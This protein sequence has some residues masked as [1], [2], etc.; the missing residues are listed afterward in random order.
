M[1]SL[2]YSFFIFLFI[3]PKLS[4]VIAVEK[5]FV[6]VVLPVRSRDFWTD[7]T[8]KT[9]DQNLILAKN[10][11]IPFTFLLQYD[12]LKDQEIVDL[13]KAITVPHEIGLFL[14]VGELLAT[15]TKVPYL[16]GSGDWA[17]PDKVFLSG[18]SVTN[19]I[20]MIDVLMKKFKQIF[21]Y[22]PVSVGA[23]YI[24]AASMNYLKEKYNIQIALTA[25]DQYSTDK[26]HLWGKYF[27]FPFYSSKYNTLTPTQT[28]KNKLDVVQIQWAFRD[29]V[30]SYGHSAF[31]S[32]YSLQAN[33]YIGHKLKTSYF[34]YIFNIY[35]DTTFNKFAQITVGLEVGSDMQSTSEF[36]NQ[37]LYL[38]TLLKQEKIQ[39]VTMKDFSEWYKKANPTFSP[40]MIITNKNNKE[41]PFYLWFMSPYYRLFLSTQNEKLVIKDLH[42]FDEEFLEKDYLFAD[43]R[44]T[45][46]R[47]VTAEIDQLVLEN[48]KTLFSNV[49]YSEIEQADGDYKI[50]VELTEGKK[51]IIL[52]DKYFS[53]DGKPYQS[54][55]TSEK[56]SQ[57]N[58]RYHNLVL[59]FSLA[60]LVFNHFPAILTTTINSQKLIGFPV[61]NETFFG[62][63]F[64]PLKIGVFHFPFQTIAFF[65]RFPRL[66]LNKWFV[67]DATYQAQKV[68]RENPGS[69]LILRTEINLIEI[70]SKSKEMKRILENSDYSIWKKLD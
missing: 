28:E 53:L 38:S 12:V 4:A 35:A 18:Y 23:W 43:Q 20:K 10:S 30:K 15:D 7:S 59:L 54:Q 42:I 61:G 22:Y 66:P 51:E 24:D 5:P 67:S 14:E 64:S 21:G 41:S 8:I 57:E 44:T 36:N 25:S 48:E 34:E 65:K 62:L 47:T 37:I 3:L 1:K 58:K 68:A 2:I 39:A 46:F 33:D 19:R 32:T 27:G 17:R 70:A 26:Y 6:T 50:T 29:P 45:L 11:Q 52:S 31:D 69:E 60:D 13:L 16:Q 55:I 9:L 63:A 40:K 56:I 49:R